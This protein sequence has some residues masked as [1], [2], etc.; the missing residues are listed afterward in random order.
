MRFFYII[1]CIWVQLIIKPS[2]TYLVRPHTKPVW[3]WSAI[4]KIS[5]GAYYTARRRSRDTLRNA[6]HAWA[7]VCLSKECQVARY[8]DVQVQQ[9]KLQLFKAGIIRI[10]C[11]ASKLHGGI[12]PWHI[13]VWPTW[14]A[15]IRRKV[16]AT[17]LLSLKVVHC[18]LVF[19]YNVLLQTWM[20]NPCSKVHDRRVQVCFYYWANLKR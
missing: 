6:R 7:G 1:I 10:I 3:Q 8:Y 4:E 19:T 16:D 12:H 17:Q 18:G 14:D 13:D 2:L 9:V 15:T 20:K 11:A 5:L